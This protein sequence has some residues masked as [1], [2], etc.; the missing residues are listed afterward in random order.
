MADAAAPNENLGIWFSPDNAKVD[1]GS[2]TYLGNTGTPTGYTYYLKATNFGFAIPTGA[3]INGVTVVINRKS[4]YNST[5]YTTDRIVSLVKNNSVSGDNNADTV[6][7][8]PTSDGNASYGGASSLWGNTFSAEDINLETFGVVLQATM[9]RP[10]KGSVYAYVDFISITVTYS[11]GGGTT[12]VP[13]PPAALDCM[14][15]Y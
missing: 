14:M 11:E 2:Y 8:W 3:T 6:S 9:F 15:V 13:R 10:S 5:F 1:D 7:K 12:Y 4:S